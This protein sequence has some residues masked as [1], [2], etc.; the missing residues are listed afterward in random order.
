LKRG[1]INTRR[2]VMKK[3]IFHAFGGFVAATAVA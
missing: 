1:I 3:W 2:T